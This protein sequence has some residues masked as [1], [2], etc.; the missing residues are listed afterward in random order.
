ML[1]HD[2]RRCY[3]QNVDMSLGHHFRSPSGNLYFDK[4]RYWCITSVAEAHYNKLAIYTYQGKGLSE[5]SAAVKAQHVGVR[6]LHIPANEYVPQNDFTPLFVDTM[7]RKRE[8]LDE[9]SVTNFTAQ[10]SASFEDPTRVVGRVCSKSIARLR[11]L[12][13]DWE[14]RHTGT[15]R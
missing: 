6:P 14:D 8:H 2:S 1:S 13:R 7:H 11:F 10:H 5:E 9:R 12:R 3:D 4:L 15:E